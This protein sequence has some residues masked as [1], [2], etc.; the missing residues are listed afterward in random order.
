MLLL[1]QNLC[2]DNYDHYQSSSITY[3]SIGSGSTSVS[4]K[5]LVKYY[6][7]YQLSVKDGQV[8]VSDNRI[9]SY[10]KTFYKHLSYNT[11]GAVSGRIACN[12]KNR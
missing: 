12:I 8:D 1:A 9:D 10:I 7:K 2:N 11:L 5:P 3:G 4:S 6:R